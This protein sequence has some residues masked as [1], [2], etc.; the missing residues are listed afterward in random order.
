VEQ[1]FFM[2]F[3]GHEMAEWLR[4]EFEVDLLSCVRSHFLK[5]RA[6]IFVA[7]AIKIRQPLFAQKSQKALG[8]Y[9]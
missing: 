4:L 1:F 5:P 2:Y 7:L 6:K 9:S 3:E 8:E